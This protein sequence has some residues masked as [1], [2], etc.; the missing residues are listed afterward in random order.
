M[1]D[2]S[3]NLMASTTNFMRYESSLTPDQLAM[4]NISPRIRRLT[5]VE[6]ERLQTVEDNYT[7]CVS[8]TQRYKMLGNGWTVDVIAHIFGFIK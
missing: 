4:S 6:A 3:N 5:P 8:D 7:A 1:T 2:K